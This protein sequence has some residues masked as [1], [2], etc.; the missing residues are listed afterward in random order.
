M[1]NRVSWLSREMTRTDHELILKVPDRIT[2]ILLSS[3]D[4]MQDGLVT[5]PHRHARV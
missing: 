2:G 3:R 5:H 1:L 4:T